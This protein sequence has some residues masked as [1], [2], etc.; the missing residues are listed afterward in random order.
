MAQ[1]PEI[2]ELSFVE[3]FKHTGDWSWFAASNEVLGNKLP[4]MVHYTEKLKKKSDF[5]R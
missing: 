5:I 1:F 4:P 2:V 3:C